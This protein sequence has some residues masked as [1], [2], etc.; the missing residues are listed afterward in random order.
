MQKGGAILNTTDSDLTVN[1]S[2]FFDNEAIS[3]NGEA[4]GGAIYNEGSL[5]FKGSNVFMR[6]MANETP[7]DIH[8][9]GN[10]FVEGHLLINDGIFIVFNNSPFC[11]NIVCLSK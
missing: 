2:L 6:N 9:E 3:K 11:V 7:N 1:S 4:Q 10:I 5:T 8:N